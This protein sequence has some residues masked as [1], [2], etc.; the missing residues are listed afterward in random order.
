MIYTQKMQKAVRFAIKTHDIYQKQLR[1]GKPVAYITH[2][3]AVGIILSRAGVEEDVVIAGI[4]HDTIEDSIEEKKVTF[5]MLNERFG[6]R[7]A[8]IVHD[9]TEEDKAL[10][11]D[12]RKAR[13]LSHIADFTQETLLV[14]SA[15]TIAN[16]ADLINDHAHQGDLA[17]QHFFAPK[18]IFVGH[19]IK[20]IDAINQKWEENPLRNDLMYVKKELLD[21]KNAHDHR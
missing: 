21:I 13:A 18:E 6:T 5:E 8:K 10:P 11:W 20:V 16:C 3:L 4:L 14:K 12:E 19:Y 15:D 2:P 17:F 1:K 9:V 7:V